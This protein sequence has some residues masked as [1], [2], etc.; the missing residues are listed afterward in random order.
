[1]GADQ[2]PIQRDFRHVVKRYETL[3]TT[4]RE[5][6]NYEASLASLEES[7]LGIRQNESVKRLT[8]LV[9]IFIPVSIV[10]SIFGMNVDVLSGDGAKWW[11]VI[12]GIVVTYIFLAVPLAMTF[13][14]KIKGRKTRIYAK[15]GYT[16]FRDRR[17][18]RRMEKRMSKSRREPSES[19]VDLEKNDVALTTIAEVDAKPLTDTGLGATAET[20]LR[21]ESKSNKETGTKPANVD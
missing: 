4:S 11:T 16:A 6:L 12:V 13:K 18:D 10:T 15:S 5:R 8:Q 9:F 19:S 1:M 2:H 7:R 20:I 14:E 21:D 17:T 3:H